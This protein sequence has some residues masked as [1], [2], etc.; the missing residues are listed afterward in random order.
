MDSRGRDPDGTDPH[1]TDPH[2]T[3]PDEMDWDVEEARSRIGKPNPH[4]WWQQPPKPPPDPP[5][6]LVLRGTVLRYVLI[7]L[8]RLRGP[9]T[10][11]DLVAGLQQ[12]G[13][14]VEGRPSKTVS[15]ALR[16]ERR[17]GRVERRGRGRYI[18]GDIARST[19]HRIIRRVEALREQARPLS[20]EG[21]HDDLLSLRGGHSYW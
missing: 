6:P 11:P 20:L 15:D 8:L 19:E 4:A 1:G 2:A 13:F 21:G 16:W 3:D 14:A 7:Y 5:K 12:W 17:R 18:A 10:I 9:R